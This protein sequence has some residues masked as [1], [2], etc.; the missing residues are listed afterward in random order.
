[1]P[2][3]TEAMAT[4]V[5]TVTN[6]P[7]QFDLPAKEFIGYDPKGTTTIT[8]SQ[9]II[10]P[11]SAPATEPATAPVAEVPASEVQLPAKVSAIARK[12][13]AQRARERTIQ[14][15][16]RTFADKMSDADKYHALKAKIAAKDYS[17]LDEL[18][19][20]Y[21]EIVKHELNKEALKDPTKEE[22]R[23]L[24]EEQVKLRKSLEEKEVKEY[25]AN[26]ALW[27]AEIVRVVSEKPEFAAI[28]KMD[29]FDTVLQHIND[30]FEE[31]GTEL[32]VEQA[33]KDIADILTERAKK[34]TSVLEDVESEVPAAKVLGA[35][36]TE[37]KTI[38]QNMT[39]TSVKPVAK[40]F[41][42]MSES[43]QLAEAIRKVQ[44]AKLQR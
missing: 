38:T 16:E 1:M 32:T 24:K 42:L 31:D 33:S 11:T 14:E 27:K 7:N 10:P 23:L 2:F 39:T 6:Q 5:G 18:G 3:T 20:A 17:G 34:W 8:G 26:Q 36:K 37:V 44:A 43:E 4:P 13:A 19:V 15:K 25:E 29:A 22:L 30:S 40:P 41:H 9:R 28:K 35:P 21:E 12:E